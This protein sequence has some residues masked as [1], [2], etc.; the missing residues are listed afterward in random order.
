M[1][2]VGYEQLARP[3]FCNRRGAVV[4]I[5]IV[6]LTISLANRVPFAALLKAP[7]VHSASSS[8]KIQ[9]RDK[10]AAQWVTPSATFT[11]LW[12]AEASVILVEN[13]RIPVGLQDDSL[14]NRPPPV[15]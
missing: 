7:T 5:A 3:R 13:R 11:L 4:L 14:H 9:H 10:D 1:P 2:L 8:A 15:S 12:T 6:A